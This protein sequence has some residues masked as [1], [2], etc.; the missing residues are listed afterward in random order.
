MPNA[1]QYDVRKNSTFHPVVLYGLSS[2][3]SG[4]GMRKTCFPGPHEGNLWLFRLC[5]RLALHASVKTQIEETYAPWFVKTLLGH[6]DHRTFK[7]NLSYCELM[8]VD[9]EYFAPADDAEHLSS[10]D[11]I[12]ELARSVS[13]ARTS[14]EIKRLDRMIQ[15]LF[16]D[17][18]RAEITSR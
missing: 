7:D 11:E 9:S 10:P 12:V 17:A 15:D 18:A 3:L 5:D 8:S 4:L 6:L 13:S 2:H 16:M 1:E 14:R